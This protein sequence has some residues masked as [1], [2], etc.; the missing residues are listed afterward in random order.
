MVEAAALPV[1]PVAFLGGLAA[2]AGAALV[3][4]GLADA[5]LTIL[6]PDLDGRFS[7]WLN[8]GIWRVATTLA[9]LR[10]AS[11]SAILGMAGPSMVVADILLWMLMPI[12]GYGLLVWPFLGG[13]FDTPPRLGTD[14]WDALYFSGVTFTTLGYGDITPLSR[15][16]E[17]LAVAEAI[18][19][20][21][22]MSTALAYIVAVFEGVDQRDALALQVYSETGGTWRGGELISRTLRDE[23]V[24]ALRKRVEAWASLVRSLHGRLYRFHGL[25]L[26]LRTHGL[27]RGPERMM[28][29]LADATLRVKVLARHPGM[30][31][32]GPAADHLAVAVEHFARAIV[33]RHGSAACR[34]ALDEGA[35]TEEDARAV[36]DAWE[37]AAAALHPAP[38]VPD[39]SDDAELLALAARLRIFLGEID[40][41]T[42]WRTLDGRVDPRA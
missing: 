35:P 19:G 2:L 32:V 15:A 4:L 13:G 36:R 28:Y 6:H 29:A 14:L 3:L 12:A 42:R 20:V 38:P 30:R 39:P 21:L 1:V 16:W 18:T 37:G 10:P 40:R 24:E 31:R 33:R 27:D 11:R 26:Y 23:D 7:S 8:R 41:L 34:R 17:F 25:A 9:R 22:V 5:F